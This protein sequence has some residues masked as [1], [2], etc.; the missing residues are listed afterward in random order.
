MKV[1]V[2][3]HTG[4]AI[5]ISGLSPEEG[6]ALL[7]SRGLTPADIA[8][9]DHHIEAG[10]LDWAEDVCAVCGAHLGWGVKALHLGLC[11]DCAA[12]APH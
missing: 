3:L 5:D 2:H 11:E 9:T 10:T 8:R 4:E 12:K 1:I 6:V 7:K